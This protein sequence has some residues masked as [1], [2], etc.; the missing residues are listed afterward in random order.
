MCS[1]YNAFNGNNKE[2]QAPKLNLKT[3]PIM[4]NIRNGPMPPKRMRLDTDRVEQKKSTQTFN[5]KT[6]SNL[7]IQEQKRKL[8]VFHNRNKLLELIK[9]H[10]TLIILGETG[11]GKTTQIPQYIYSARLHGN[12]KIAITQPRRVAAVSIANRVAKEVGDGVSKHL[13]SDLERSSC[14]VIDYM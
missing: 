11:C 7:N 5:G 6:S 2:R 14:V 12:S 1:K 8:P 10:A 9:K 13:F 3:K 4:F